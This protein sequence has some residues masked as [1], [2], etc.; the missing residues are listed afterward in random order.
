[1]PAAG[2]PHALNTQRRALRFAEGQAQK[3]LWLV[4]CRDMWDAADEDAGV[5]FC[6]EKTTESARLLVKSALTQPNDVRVLGVY[7]LQQD[8]VKQGPG[9]KAEEFLQRFP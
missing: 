6:I 8:L 2:D 9:L 1:M 7:S 4:E 5:Y 3:A